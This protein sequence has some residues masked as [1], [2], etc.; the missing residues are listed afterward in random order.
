MLN[1]TK[2]EYKLGLNLNTIKCLPLVFSMAC[3]SKFFLFPL[4]FEC[5][6]NQDKSLEF[7]TF[8]IKHNENDYTIFDNK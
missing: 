5:S 1:F 4:S 6:L 7:I 3:L 8:Y 2:I